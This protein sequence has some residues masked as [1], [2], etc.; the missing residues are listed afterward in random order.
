MADLPELTEETFASTIESG[1]T[2]V[3]FW[4]PWC[5]PCQVQGPILEQVAAQAPEGAKV[6]KL[7]VDD[8]GSVAA[9]YGVMSIP[10][11]I[12]FKDGQEVERLVGV[13]QADSL[14]ALL[15][16]HV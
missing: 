11:L 9:Q 2:L 6:A 5:G 13:Q 16:K 10:T 8:V 1:V 14:I 7:N 3:D 4:A 12:I 15:K